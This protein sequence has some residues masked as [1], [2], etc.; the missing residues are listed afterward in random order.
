MPNNNNGQQII[1]LL[2]PDDAPDG[3]EDNEGGDN[4]TN[5]EDCVA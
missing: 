5:A 1:D 3:I 2:D 4:F